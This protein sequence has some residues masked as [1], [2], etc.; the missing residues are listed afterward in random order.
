MT[1][2]LAILALTVT[3]LIIECVAFANGSLEREIG[4]RPYPGL[5][6]AIVCA[7]MAAKDLLLDGFELAVDA[8]TFMTLFLVGNAMLFASLSIKSIQKN[9]AS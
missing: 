5:L 7:A 2:E 1:F 8:Q 3:A 4:E 6:I 9:N